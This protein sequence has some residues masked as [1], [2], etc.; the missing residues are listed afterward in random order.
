MRC[1]AAGRLQRLFAFG[2]PPLGASEVAR[3][4]WS[5][6]S[7]GVAPRRVRSIGRSASRSR[8]AST[9]EI[10]SGAQPERP[11]RERAHGGAGGARAE[12]CAER[13]GDHL[14]RKSDV[15]TPIARGA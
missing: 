13:F 15:L 1:R 4:R 3:M 5:T 7:A 2:A 14:R 6:S 11:G 10:S 8:G 12:V 9:R